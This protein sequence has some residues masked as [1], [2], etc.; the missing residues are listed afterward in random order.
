[1]KHELFIFNKSIESYDHKTLIITDAL[2]K[3]LIE[4]LQF[5]AGIVYGLALYEST[6]I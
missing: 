6:T 1:M 2:Q 5:T 3:M 4:R